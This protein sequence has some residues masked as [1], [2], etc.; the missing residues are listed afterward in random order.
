MARKRQSLKPDRPLQSFLF[1]DTGKVRRA[2]EHLPRTQDDLELV[3]GQKF[4]GAMSYFRKQRLT[5]MISGSGRGDVICR[6]DAGMQVKIQVVEAVNNSKAAWKDRNDSYREHLLR[7]YPEV[8]ALFNGCRLILFDKAGIGFSTNLRTRHG[9]IHL[10]EL[11]KNLKIIG[12]EI[13]SLPTGMIR[14]RKMDKVP[15]RHLLYSTVNA[16]SQQ[17]LIFHAKFFAAL[18]MRSF[19]LSST[20]LR[21]QS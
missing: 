21:T 2:V 4:A 10:D 6:N 19:L 20:C 12:R 13:G 15:Q 3:I 11:A 18:V 8:F 16:P 1:S 7:K 9:Q 5:E 17:T 14:R